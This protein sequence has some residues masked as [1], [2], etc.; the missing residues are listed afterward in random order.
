MGGD[1]RSAAVLAVKPLYTVAELATATGCSMRATL[2][3]LRARRIEITRGHSNVVTLAELQSK[4][5]SL[6]ESLQIAETARGWSD[7]G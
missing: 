6:I 1:A 4:W 5:P 3:V 7:V 2:G